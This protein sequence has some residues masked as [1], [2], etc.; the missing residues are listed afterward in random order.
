[1]VKSAISPIVERM[2]NIRSEQEIDE[3]NTELEELGLKNNSGYEVSESIEIFGETLKEIPLYQLPVSAGT[4]E[5]LGEGYEYELVHFDNIPAEADFALKVR[6]D[7]MEPEFLDGE[8][9][10]VKKSVIVLNGQVG[11]F[12]L[13][14]EGY[15]KQLQDDR[16]VSINE[17]YEP[18][19]VREYD[20]FDC[21]GRVVGKQELTRI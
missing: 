11:I 17:K 2:K 4:G 16:L 18:I 21:A 20:R 7:S 12:L 1:M 13:N 14:G 19:I 10:F 5:F 9:V 15:L 6:G 8:I 3:I